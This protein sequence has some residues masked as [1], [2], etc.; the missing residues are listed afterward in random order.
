MDADE[1]RPEE[2]DERL[3]EDVADA[4]ASFRRS[5]ATAM[6]MAGGIV[7][8]TG[9]VLSGVFGG[10]KGLASAF[11]GFA[12]ASA[13]AIV[14]M[15]VLSWAVKKP[16]QWLL[17]IQLVSYV[18]RLVLLVGILFALHFAK[19]LD[20]IALLSCFLALYIAQTAVEMFFARRA[21][22][23][24]IKSAGGGGGLDR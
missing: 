6:A 22:G 14:A 17:P 4:F 8:P 2:G 12:V 19:A 10:W 13:Y 24:V 9:L 18:I 20:M 11:I 1:E 16:P 5:T 23:A 3:P 7:I 21:F 15:R